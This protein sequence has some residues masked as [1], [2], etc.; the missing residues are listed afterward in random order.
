[1]TTSWASG[2]G[3]GNCIN[4]SSRSPLNTTPRIASS[5]CSCWW[6]D[7]ERK[8]AI[9]KAIHAGAEDALAYA[10]CPCGPSN[11][12]GGDID[13]QRNQ[14]GIV[15]KGDDAVRGGGAADGPVGNA[16]IGHLRGHADHE[17]EIKK[18]PVIGL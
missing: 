17:R 4:S 3:S 13:H 10:S 12:A 8:D 15:N 16:D 1:M 7:L 11:G 5:A 18:I 6:F 14:R 2:V 9:G